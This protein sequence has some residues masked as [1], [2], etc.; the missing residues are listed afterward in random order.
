MCARS[1]ELYEFGD[2]RLDATRR[3]VSRAGE[4]LRLNSKAFET[5]L[6]LVRNRRR[7][8]TKDE[9]MTTLWPDTFVEEVN[10]A[11][12]ISAARKLLGESPG[13]N[14]FIVTV[15]G[16]GY[17]FVGEVREVGPPAEEMPSGP[18]ARTESNPRVETTPGNRVGLPIP[19]PR[20][21]AWVWMGLALAVAIGAAAGT[22]YFLKRG[23]FDRGNHSLAVLPFQPLAG[24]D[25][26]DHLGL[27]MADAVITKLINLRQFPVRPTDVAIRYAQPNADALQAGR[28]MGVDTVL[29][30][31]IQKG[32]GRVRVTVQLVAVRDGRTLWAQTFDEDATSIF[33]V[34]DSISERVAQALAVHLAKEDKLRLQRHYTEN[35]DA[36]RSY[37]EG[38]YEEFTFTPQ[39]MFKAIEHFNHA[40]ADDP[41]YALA[42]AGLAD[43]YTT[44]SDWLLAPREA[45]PKAEAAA[46]KALVFDENLAE[47]HGALAH[48]LLHEWRLAESAQEFQNALALNPGNVST[49]FAYAEYLSS[50][51]RFDDA[52]ATMK[53]ALTIDP[54]SP[55]VNS[56]L[57]WDYY[58]DRDYDNCLLVSH[59]AMQLFPDFWVPHMTAGMCYYVRA[60]NADALVEFRRALAMNPAS[61][62]SQAGLA[63]SLAKAGRR[64][65]SLQE[66]QQLKDMQKE[67]YVSPAYVAI[68]YHALD[69]D[70]QEFAW[71]EKGYEDQ[72]EWLLWLRFEPMFDGQR[73]D[74]RFQALVKKVGV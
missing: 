18:P 53:K 5:L 28:A 36:Y 44:E 71:L 29:A 8:M 17:Q 50:V 12:N 73:E 39:G 6:V 43:A 2:F 42:Y 14:R 46:R 57:A 25:D 7:V 33:S 59:N 55:E 56:F 61:T 40:L 4:P 49:Y 45:L 23:V 60:Q 9:L 70:R 34:E 66:L 16:K 13:E 1:N 22:A 52:I 24:T 11:Q 67:T 63:M 20:R 74:P 10:L 62:Y 37:L 72:A 41:G 21:R 65:E 68:V 15:P 58:L 69:D 48:A 38:R 35:I 64:A 27:G 31:K 54:L 30:G 51:G 3:I 26:P 47:A 19:L 32:N